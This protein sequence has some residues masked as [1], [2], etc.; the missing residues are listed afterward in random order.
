MFS[1]KLIEE[2]EK[3][4][5]CY[6]QRRTSMIEEKSLNL[7]GAKRNNI[8]GARDSHLFRLC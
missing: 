6:V 5:K 2:K 4:L 8:D 7:K 3:R 1:D